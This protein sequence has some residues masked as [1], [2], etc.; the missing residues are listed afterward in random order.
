MTGFHKGILYGKIG[1]VAENRERSSFP[2]KPPR[3]KL[4]AVRSKNTH[5]VFP[6]KFASEKELPK[7]I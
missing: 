2:P 7:K 4:Q 5:R 1:M 6:L 3:N